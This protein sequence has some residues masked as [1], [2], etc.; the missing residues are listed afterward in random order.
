[1]AGYPRKA[2]GQLGGVNLVWNPNDIFNAYSYF[3][4]DYEERPGTDAIRVQYYLNSTSTAEVAYQPGRTSNQTIA[5]GLY[6]FTKG[7]YDLQALAGIVTTDYVLGGGW[8][9]VLGKAGFNGEISAFVPR[10]DL[11]LSNTVISASVGVNY[12]F[13]RSLYLLGA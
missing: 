9:G 10:K 5:A 8:S 7:S 1:M 11:R 13:P 12:T 6:R 4:F 2:K 3:D